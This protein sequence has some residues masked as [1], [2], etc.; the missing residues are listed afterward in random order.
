MKR[1]L[2]MAALFLALFCRGQQSFEFTSDGVKQQSAGVFDEEGKLIRT[3]FT[4]QVFPSGTNT[5][6]W[7]GKDDLGKIVPQGKYAVKLLSHNLKAEW[8]GTIANTSKQASNSVWGASKRHY[9]YYG[10]AIDI[11]E[12]TNGWVYYATGYSEANVTLKKFHLDSTDVAVSLKVNATSDYSERQGGQSLGLATTFNICSDGQYLY[13]SGLTYA[14]QTVVNGSFVMNNRIFITKFDL[15]NDQMVPFS[16]GQSISPAGFNYPNVIVLKDGLGFHGSWPYAISGIAVD[17]NFLFA[18][19]RDQNKVSVFNK[20]TG[21]LISSTTSIKTPRR[22]VSDGAFLWIIYGDK[23]VSKFAVGGNGTI[24]PTPLLTLTGLSDPHSLSVQTVS[25]VKYLYVSDGGGQQVV[26]RFKVSDGQLDNMFN[27]GRGYFG[28]LGGYTNS[29]TVVDDRFFFATN[30]GKL[31]GLSVKQDG[32]F[33]LCDDGNNRMLRYNNTLSKTHQ[34]E[35]QGATYH[36]QMVEG[37]SSRLLSGLAEFKVDYTSPLRSS[38]K[39]TNQYEPSTGIDLDPGL[40]FKSLVKFPNGRTY[41]FHRTGKD[42]NN[43]TIRGN[44]YYVLY[45]LTSSGLRNTGIYKL[46]FDWS[47][48]QDGS[49]ISCSVRPGGSTVVTRFDLK[50]FDAAQNPQWAGTGTVI[51]K[52]QTVGTEG[53][54]G[55][56]VSRI[57]DDGKLVFFDNSAPNNGISPYSIYNQGYHIGAINYDPS[58]G[59]TSQNWIWRSALSTSLTYRGNYPSDGKFDIGNGT[60]FPGGQAQTVGDFITWNH[61]GE[62]WKQG[63]T[64]MHHLMYKNGLQLMQFGVATA[65]AQNI[66]PKGFPGMAGNALTTAVTKVGDALYVWHGDEGYHSGIHRWKVSGINNVKEQVIPLYKTDKL[67]A[68]F[69]LNT[70]FGCSPLEVNFSDASDPGQEKIENWFWD[71]GD[72][73]TSSDQNPSHTFV[74]AGKYSVSLKVKNA[75]GDTSVFSLPDSIV[76]SS[77][78]T[79]SISNDTTGCVSSK[80]TFKGTAQSSL[81]SSLS[82][83]WDFGNGQKSTSADPE[84]QVYASDGSYPISVK[85]TDGYGCSASA[86]STFLALIG[87][88]INIGPDVEICQ[89]DVA[90]LSVSGAEEYTWNNA[91]TLTCGNC[92]TP[93]ATPTQTT[94]YTVTGSSGSGCRAEASVTVKVRQSHALSLA[95]TEEICEGQSVYLAADG[96]DQYS[97]TPAADVKDPNSGVTTATPKISTL[98]TVVGRDKMGCFMDTASIFVTVRSSPKVNAGTDFA[99]CKGSAQQLQATGATWYQWDYASTLSC[100]DCRSPLAAPTTNTQFV[101][102]GVDDFGCTATDSV[103]VTVHQPFQLA[104]DQ[105]ADICI[106]QSARL[107]ATGADQYSWSPAAGVSNPSLGVTTVTPQGSTRYTVTAKDKYNC[108]TDTASVYVK[109]WPYP[110]VETGEAKTLQVG[111]SLELLPLYSPDVTRYQWTPA[112]TL[113]CSN[114]P[115]PYANPISQTTYKVTV[116]NNGG[117]QASASVTVHVICNGGNLFI[118]NTFSPNGDGRNDRFYVKGIGLSKVKAL[119]IYNRWGELVFAR[120]NMPANNENVGWD[121]T[122]KGQALPPDVYIYTCE[123]V[124]LNNEVLTYNGDVTLLR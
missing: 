63:Q 83:E 29:S 1:L 99:I 51:G 49:L 119:K 36:L 69:S 4:G 91:A 26:K 45:E 44:T 10:A 11:Y 106:G 123:V 54:N 108:F 55:G 37:D 111:K 70:P 41:G 48:L 47:I 74:N 124:C 67:E 88:K 7:D 85:V 2:T 84:P 78:P 43:G 27:S 86:Q 102:T 105:P 60:F 116:S 23:I 31:A 110:T 12:H 94:V 66:M 97:W 122:A 87:P 34:V 15:S 95:K 22:M 30:N 79:V 93:A 98:Y 89:G 42:F 58:N 65:N 13:A 17:G 6:T 35:W 5:Y 28:Q 115:S 38:W 18:A 68:N 117:C 109:V 100:T 62:F 76:V 40:Y 80:V 21:T 33:W 20:T 46:G 59:A 3:L 8:E 71:F 61:H 75:A 24:N 113:N 73:T 112:E 53:V 57:T 14:A 121:G 19:Q 107:A 90:K 101:V 104:V 39:L 120:E 114:C 56:L 118:P 103:A 96:V 81:A 52:I 82:W 50:G 9:G 72:G 64:N 32:S 25:G 92:A 16:A 77:N